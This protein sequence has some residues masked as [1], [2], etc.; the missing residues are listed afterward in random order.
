[1]CV[2]SGLPF[3]LPPSGWASAPGV[4]FPGGL[5]DTVSLRFEIQPVSLTNDLERGLRVG[6][7]VLAGSRHAEEVQEWIPAYQGND[8]NHFS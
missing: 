4:S 8:R 1:M 7:V 2:G 3:A 6:T 5:I